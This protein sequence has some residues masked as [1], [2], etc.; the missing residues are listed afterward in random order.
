MD[1]TVTAANIFSTSPAI[2]QNKLVVLED[3]KNIFLAG[4]RRAAGG[5]AE[6]IR[7]AQDGARRRSA[8]LTTEALIE[9]N[10]AVEGN[11]GVDPDE[12]AAKWIKDNGFD[13]ADVAEV[14][15]EVISFENVTQ[16]V[17]RRH[18]CGRRADAWR[19]RRAR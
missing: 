1:G 10:T 2:E 13:Q 4:E 11:P 19:C 18:R 12:A 9:L 14:S 15:W 7:R 3:P 5:F 16:G 6:E 8:K 17:S